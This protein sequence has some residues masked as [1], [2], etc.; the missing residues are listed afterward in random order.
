MKA[1]IYTIKG[2]T[3]EDVNLPKEYGEKFSKSLLLQAIRVYEDGTHFGLAKVQTRSEVNRTRKKLYKQKGTGGARHGARSAPIF[4][5]GGVA[6]GPKGVKRVLNL[7]V[8][9][10]KKALL[11][12]LSNKFESKKAVLIEGLEKISKTAEGN[13]MLLALRKTLEVKSKILIVLSKESMKLTR[14][15]KNIKDI[16]VI[17]FESLNAFKVMSKSLILIE[18]NIFKTET[19]KETKVGKIIKKETKK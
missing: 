4:V 10:K 13:N 15:F 18:S 16:E 6:H 7:P 1:K 11:A 14:F 9:M 5:G 3:K 8:K 17:G 12:A 19:K 2:E